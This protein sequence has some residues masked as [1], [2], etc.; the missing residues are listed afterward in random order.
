[1]NIRKYTLNFYRYIY[2]NRISFL[3]PTLLI[4]LIYGN[5]IYKIDMR[6]DTENMI[7]QP[8][9]SSAFCS[10]G[11]Q[12]IAL[13]KL[14]FDQ[15]NFNPYFSM[16]IGLLVLSFSM[17][18]LSYLLDKIG[19][20]KPLH[21]IIMF[22]I[23]II[24]PIWAEQFYFRNQFLEINVGLLLTILAVG[25]SYYS[26]IKHNNLF[27]F[28]SIIIMI[29]SFSTYQTFVILYIALCI[30]CFM[31]YYRNNIKLN[32]NKCNIKLIFELI[33]LFMV[34]FLINTIITKMFFVKDIPYLNS[35][36]QWNQENF[37]ICIKNI[38]KNIKNIILGKGI[39]YSITYTISLI[40]MLIFSFNYIIINRKKKDIILYLVSTILLEICPFL[41]TI[42]TANQP[43]YRSQFVLPFVISCNIIIILL[44]VYKKRYSP[45]LI[46][47]FIAVT[48]ILQMQTV[49]RLEYTDQVRYEQDAVLA[50]QIVDRISLETNSNINKPVAFVGAMNA[51]LNASCVEGE[52]IGKSIFNWN[53][54]ELPHYQCSSVRICS[55]INNLGINIRN[56]SVN[57]MQEAR[58]EAQN[59][60]SW[61]SKGC[62]RDNGDF[63]IIK[64]SEDKWYF[65]DMATAY[66]T[67][68]NNK[69]IKFEDKQ[70]YS[71]DSF[72]LEN[73]EVKIGGWF[74]DKE[75]DSDD[76]K[77]NIYLLNDENSNIFEINTGRQTRTD[78]T[79]YFK[80][81]TNYDNSGFI[82]KGDLSNLG[83]DISKYRIIIGY[84]HNDQEK[85]VDTKHYLN[86]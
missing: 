43:V 71:I 17:I 78:V 28:L 26:I 67:K 74:I 3:I 79:S 11:R 12:G 13:T 23:F 45:I 34:A 60:T 10:L 82:T 64:L 36:I 52:T 15:L 32:I 35:Q 86:N 16:S 33:V 63:I 38:L 66:S 50:N 69:I 59:M 80:D 9:K 44:F 20:I 6:I 21:S 55:S 61:P 73:N 81:G 29:W 48:F 58:T 1:M 46:Y 76:I 68:Y 57:Q 62:I 5:E 18:T 70:T 47:F 24:H 51:K 25:I 85:F 49:L 75:V 2:N 56:V 8:N 65:S 22:L 72:S 30:I 42:Y 53:A 27:K 7:N 39:F 77:I 54:E 4:F 19:N 31:L 83:S 41:L 84:T 40:I 14:L 37:L